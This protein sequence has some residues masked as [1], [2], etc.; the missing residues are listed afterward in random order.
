ML[1]PFLPVLRLVI[2]GTMVG[3]ARAKHKA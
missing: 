2:T 3:R 1:E